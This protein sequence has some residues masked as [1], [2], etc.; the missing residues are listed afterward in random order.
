MG[1]N[2]LK[3]FKNRISDAL[4]IGAL[5]KFRTRIGWRAGWKYQR[6]HNK[7]KSEYRS[8]SIMPS[9]VVV[10]AA[11]Q[12]INVGW[13]AFAPPKTRD[14]TKEIMARLNN[15]ESQSKTIWGEGGRFIGGDLWSEF[16]VMEQIFSHGLG[17]FI[18]LAM[19]SHYKIFYGLMYKSE[20]YDEEPTGSQLWHADGGPGTCMNLMLCLSDVNH[21]NG[22][23][24]LL[25]WKDS[26]RIFNKERAAVRGI[27][28]GLLSSDK[29][30]RSALRDQRAKWIQSVIESEQLT[31]HQP[32]GS[33]GMM[34][35]FNNNLMHRGGFVQKGQKRVVCV[36][37]IYPSIQ[38]VP[39]GYYRRNGIEKKGPY[40]EP[41][42]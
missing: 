36:F 33:S 34:L 11:H 13:A 5:N 4:W 38:P 23:M 37:H 28:R 22:A 40:P 35:A 17:D 39:Y 8:N 41:F 20:R 42:F 2:F 6:H 9:G 12:Y 3:Q 24:E 26:L 10:E 16:P 19:G 27:T 7:A 14:Y 18:E 32:E 25:D 21:K 31:V 1:G 15:M 29:S 30:D